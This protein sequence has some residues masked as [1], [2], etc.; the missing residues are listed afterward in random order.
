MNQ[1][2]LAKWYASTMH[3]GQKYG[4]GSDPHTYH[5]EQVERTLRR[6]GFDEEI[7]LVCAW[8]HDTI[9]DVR[10]VTYLIL[11][12]GF[13]K[14]V[15]D[16]VFCVTNQMGRNR[17][18]KFK[19][20]YPKIRENKK[21]LIVKLA[22]RISNIE[23]GLGRSSSYVRMYRKEWPD[24]KAALFD[25]NET[26]PRIHKMWR[27]LELLFEDDNEPK[28]TISLRENEGI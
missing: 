7:Y 21:A 3:Y 26:D 27:Q 14:E 20:T 11:R 6:F 24:F 2:E 15:A 13:G 4:N 9:E 25:P 22:D 28:Q 17:K 5:L 8:L 16:I 23:N 18:E 10:G 1:Y 19:Y 12:E